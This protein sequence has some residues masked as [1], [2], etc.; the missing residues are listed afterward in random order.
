MTTENPDKLNS[1]LIAAVDRAHERAY[2]NTQRTY[3]AMSEIGNDCHRDLWLGWRWASPVKP[4]TGQRVR[5]FKRGDREE[6]R[7]VA[8]L[9]AAGLQVSDVDPATGRQWT[10]TMARGHAMVRID[11]AVT[12]PSGLLMSS[13]E[14]VLLEAKTHNRANFASFGKHG[15][16]KAHPKHY[17]QVQIGMAKAGLDK[18]LYY[19]RNKDDEND[20]AVE[21]PF[22]KQ[23]AE[24]AEMKA[25]TL[26]DAADPPAR[27]SID[28]NW[29]RCRMCANRDA[30]HG[31]AMPLRN[32]RTCAFARP[33]DDGKW[34]C[35][36]D[37]NRGLT[38]SEQLAGC[39]R[40]RFIPALISGVPELREKG[41][42]WVQYK[43][44]DGTTF[45]DN[46]SVL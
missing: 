3:L 37:D 43:M 8:D 20:A 29:Y 39:A 15:L 32:C 4:V 6:D 14:W 38:Y 2:R 13:S 21:V 26:V 44:A 7:I 9:R 45:V 19:A 36:K 41:L 42:E 27:L 17:A 31:I 12:D 24:A 22:D 1:D 23:A 33:L 28:P 11:G 18:A 10:Y 34:G 5:I 46:G 30:C 35:G 25:N 16:R 40:H